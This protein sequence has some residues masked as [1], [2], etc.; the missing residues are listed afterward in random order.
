MKP[1]RIRMV[2]IICSS[3][4]TEIVQQIEF[5]TF[6]RSFFFQ[7]LIQNLEVKCSVESGRIEAHKNVSREFIHMIIRK[8][9]DE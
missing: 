7:S 8:Q 9:T 6:S 3:V 2:E 5:N 1:I 4:Q